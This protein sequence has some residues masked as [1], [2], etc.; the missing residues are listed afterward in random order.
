[1]ADSLHQITI[2]TDDST[3]YQAL[4]TQEGI[5]SWWTGQC[6][7]A[8][9]EGD[10][11]HFWLGNRPTQFTMRS[12]KMLPNK[13]VFLVCTHGPEEWVGTELWWEI[14][15]MPNGYCQL[16][17]KHMNWNRDDG[18]FPECNSTWGLLMRQLKLYCES[19]QGSAYF[20]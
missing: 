3:L 16:D 12:Q 19:G 18:L 7:L 15:A 17:F 11:S 8:R 1:M 6:E 4:T 20:S 10:Y 2:N 9:R 14:N 5:N 13:R